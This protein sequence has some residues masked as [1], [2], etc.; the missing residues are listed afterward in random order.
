MFRRLTT[1]RVSPADIADIERR[2]HTLE[3][4]LQRVAGRTSATVTQATDHVG[5]AFVAA[6]S[7]VIDRF[8]GGARTL[9][10]EATRYEMGTPSMAAVYA[11]LGGISY[12]EEIGVQRIRER[13]IALTENLIARA[14]EAG[15]SPRVAPTV[16]E[17]TPIVLLNFDNP[18]PVVAALAQRGIIVDSRPGAV[19]V[20]PY[21][22]NTVEENEKIILRFSS[23]RGSEVS[24]QSPR[25][26]SMPCKLWRLHG[27]AAS[28]SLA[29]DSEYLVVC[30]LPLIRLVEC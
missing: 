1:M 24:R 16:E 29:P 5:D 28:V 30:E 9:G 14:I 19:R 27:G 12:V 10:D 23:T 18:R 7:D 22:Y 8:R 17:R 13:D 6:L 2:M 11:A 20:S 26:V 3:R 15:F 21:F 25:D 4:S